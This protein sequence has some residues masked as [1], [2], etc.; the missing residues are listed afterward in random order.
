MRKVIYFLQ[1]MKAV[2]IRDVLTYFRYKSWFVSLLI[3]PIVFPLTFLFL[4][5]GLAGPSNEGISNF[6]KLTGI[7][8][9]SSF[10]I[11]GNLVW[12]F[13]NIL[14]W[15]AGLFLNGL[16]RIG[17][18]DTI[19]TFPAPRLSYIFGTTTS[20]LI[21]NF[22]PIIFSFIFFRITKI[23]VFNAKIL[24][25]I[26]YTL[27]IF[28][29]IIG[30]LFIFSSL[31]LRSKEASLIVHS[32]RVLLSIFCGLQLPLKVLPK[33]LQKIG[34]IIP[35]THYINCIRDSIIKGTSLSDNIHSINYMLISGFFVLVLGI[36][37]FILVE[38][39]IR[40]KGL[41]SGY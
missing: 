15:D 24:D 31:S 19:W 39:N 28:P 7:T 27:S 36:F 37:I 29:F 32:M 30:F 10:I 6:V 41:I 11:L 9:F 21:T 26:V 8:D 23:L 40:R 22:I 34:E 14:M 18:L 13:L 2:M 3:W 38:K 1:A 25:I 35:I 4:G 17:M 12:M 5:K 20:A 33:I 16:R